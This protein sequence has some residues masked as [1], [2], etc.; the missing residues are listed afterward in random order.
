[1]RDGF[2]GWFAAHGKSGSLENSA[3]NWSAIVLAVS[4][5]SLMPGQPDNLNGYVGLG[6][7][8]LEDECPD[9]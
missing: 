3:P 7:I 6:S 4:D 2:K 8:R 5:G 9:P 1:M